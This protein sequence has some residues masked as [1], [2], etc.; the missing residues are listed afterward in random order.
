MRTF[1]FAKHR[2]VAIGALRGQNAFAR[3]ADFGRL[4]AARSGRFLPKLWPFR[5]AGMAFF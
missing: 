1:H 4:G 5:R 3:Q 2:F